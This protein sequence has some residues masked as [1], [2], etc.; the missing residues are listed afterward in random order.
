MLC[1]ACQF[2]CSHTEFMEKKNAQLTIRI[3][4]S[5]LDKLRELAREDR[6]SLNSYIQVVMEQ[7]ID[8]E[9]AE[10]VEQSAN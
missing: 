5:L 7:H 8:K 9:K 3:P 4:E 10:G 6:R 2:I 1:I